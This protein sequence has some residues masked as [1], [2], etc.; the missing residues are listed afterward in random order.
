M[1]VTATGTT[2]DA[3]P[4]DTTALPPWV[5]PGATPGG[6]R[7][8]RELPPVV[9]P[10]ATDPAALQRGY[11]EVI[12]GFTSGAYRLRVDRTFPLAQVRDG[13]DQ[14]SRYVWHGTKQGESPA[15]TLS[16]S[17]K[18]GVNA[19]DVAESVIDAVV[20]ISTKQSVNVQE[21]QMPDLPPGSPMEKTF[22]DAALGL[23]RQHAFA[24]QFGGGG[25]AKA[26][27]ALRAPASRRR[28]GST[29][30]TSTTRSWSRARCST[31][32]CT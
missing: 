16:V 20:N 11:R 29:P 27:G 19:A 7:Q 3:G 30:G 22:R 28:R 13:P 31:S 26:A 5:L 8:W 6:G 25:H 4:R 23:A 15:V 17:K 10:L 32:R 18:P 9:W 1:T 21:G 12:E 24:R 14:P 2:P